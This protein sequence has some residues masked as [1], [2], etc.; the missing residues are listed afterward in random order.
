MI[1]IVSIAVVLFL[2]AASIAGTA[3][4]AVA[5]AGAPTGGLPGGSAMLSPPTPGP[6]TETFTAA[7]AVQYAL[8]QI[9]TPY[10]WGGATAGVGFDCSGLVQS[11]WAVAGIHLPRV[12][13]DQFDAGP[14]L[15]SGSPL[16]PGD[17]V[18]FGPAGGGVT[19]VGLVVD[20]T[21]EMVDA[22]HT[23]AF[24]RLEAFPLT[25][26]ADW[27]GDIYLGATRPAGV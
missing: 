12:A 27:G 17:L 21:G 13:Q 22:P 3:V 11:A 6:T 23:G 14:R 16:Q 20:P 1:G 19:H 26:G 25:I 9:G 5:L 15:P 2:V 18:F 10:R 4:V 7:V 8:A 24:V